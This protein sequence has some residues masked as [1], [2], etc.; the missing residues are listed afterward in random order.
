MNVHVRAYV[1]MARTGARVRKTSDREKQG[2]AGVWRRDGERKRDRERM[3]LKSNQRVLLRYLPVWNGEP[4][5]E[6]A[7]SGQ[8]NVKSA[9]PA[10]GRNFRQPGPEDDTRHSSLNHPSSLREIIY[11]ILSALHGCPIASLHKRLEYAINDAFIK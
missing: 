9:L 7:R 11:A 4:W 5:R 6:R 2:G 8:N 10:P 3:G 1:H